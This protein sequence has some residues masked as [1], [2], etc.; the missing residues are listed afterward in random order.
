MWSLKNI[1][2]DTVRS[3]KSAVNEIKYVETVINTV[4]EVMSL[5][6]ESLQTTVR[7]SC[8][9][10]KINAGWHLIRIKNANGYSGIEPKLFGSWCENSIT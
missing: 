2:F 9:Y 10:D 8:Q 7:V 5:E 3:Q 6:S 4:Q 1:N